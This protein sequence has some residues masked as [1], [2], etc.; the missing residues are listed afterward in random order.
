MYIRNGV[1][2]EMQ[3]QEWDTRGFY[4]LI[5]CDTLPVEHLFSLLKELDLNPML[6][7]TTVKLYSEN[8][9]R[10]NGEYIWDDT[11]V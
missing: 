7:N 1:V 10:V 9:A 8:T 3:K 6:T 5:T 2:E 4:N 11:T